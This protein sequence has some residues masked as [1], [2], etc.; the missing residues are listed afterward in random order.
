[1]SGVICPICGATAEEARRVGDYRSLDCELCGRY[2]LTGTAEAILPELRSKHKY[3]NTLLPHWL[4][5][6]QGGAEPPSLDSALVTHIVDH[7]NLPNPAAQADNF[8]LWLG[9]TQEVPG[10]RIAVHPVR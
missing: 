1:M 4:H 6:A 8:V 2:D 9:E 5:K 3:A 7:V 10:P